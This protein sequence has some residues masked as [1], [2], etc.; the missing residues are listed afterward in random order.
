MAQ[1]Q[2]LIECPPSQVWD[3]L[4]DGHS[5]AQWVVGTRE[6]LHTDGRWPEVG[7]LLRFRAG[8]GPW[9][10]EDTCEVRICEDQRRLELEAEA[11]PFG[12]ARIAFT[13]IPWARH[14]LVILDEHPLRGL[15]ARLQGPPTE[16]ALHLRNRQLLA[17][18]ARTATR[19]RRAPRGESCGTPG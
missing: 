11:K 10:F 9:T 13:L 14:T 5:Y 15:G 4:A 6:I 7:A 1:R 12:T 18:L 16:I 2:Q 8:L 3:I 17:N 19:A